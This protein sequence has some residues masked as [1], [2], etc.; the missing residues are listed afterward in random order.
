M[1]FDGIC[2]AALTA[3]FNEKLKDGRITKLIQPEADELILT[4]KSKEGQFRLLL[5]ADPSLP[6]AYLSSQNKQA[7]MNAP[8]FCMLLR[9]HL[10]SGR[11]LSIT[12]PGLERIIRIDIE[13]LNEMGDLCSKALI[14][15]LMGRHSNIIFCEPSEDGA[16]MILDSIKHISSFVSSIRQVLP[17]RKYFIPNT[18]EK[19]DP[20]LSEI[21]YED[22]EAAINSKACSLSR[23]LYGSFTGFSPL[24]ANEL[25]HRSGLDP[26][27]PTAALS[28]LLLEGLYNNFLY[29]LRDI[30]NKSFA[31]SI[32]Y[33]LPCDYDSELPYDV[34][35]LEFSALPLSCYAE[36]KAVPCDSISLLL[37]KFYSQKNLS[38]RMSQRSHELRQLVQTAL[39]RCR[40][41]YD[42]Q[43]KQLKDT[44]KMDKYRIYGELINAFGYGVALRSREMTAENYYDDNKPIKIPLDPNMSP[45]ENSKK[46]FD[47]YQK[48]KRTKEAVSDQ[49]LSTCE[50][51][52]HL[53]SVLVSLQQAQ[54]ENDLAQIRLELANTGYLK[55][56]AK[57]SKGKAK[58]PKSEPLH[59][60][61]SDGFDI[62]VGKNN[63][64]NDEISFHL[65]NAGDWWFHAKKIAGS[66]VI[67]KNNKPGD[68]PD[69]VYEE[70][71][72]LAAYYSQGREQ[73]LVE[74]D[75]L[76][77]K[78]LKKPN[79]ARPGYVIYHTNFSISV[80]PD[81]SSLR[82]V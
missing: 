33:D 22:F 75:Y 1:A 24:L 12:Q 46:Y 71:A 14:I 80:K 58:L 73:T 7:P 26:D 34:R 41:K 56:A 42:I 62:Y 37:E 52:S 2:V 29:M 32:V 49:L 48:L 82:Q 44:E 36:K 5:S 45:Q 8:G 79:G 30:K 67:I 61:S 81:I 31:P 23:A 13:H 17:G 64:Q 51:L 57:N 76:Q 69:R 15:E 72:A 4:I 77:R 40:K 10:S 16:L 66:H 20:L 59:Y 6:L 11:I 50:E 74:V 63:L 3:E 39:D 21:S 53:S 18:Q 60:I 54:N 35:V 78:N 47:K 55:K 68:L 25:C 19:T 9:K 65:A 27:S 43:Q 38:T 28:P 70:A